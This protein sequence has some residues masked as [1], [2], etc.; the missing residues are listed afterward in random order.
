MS[1]DSLESPTSLSRNLTGAC[2]LAGPGGQSSD[3][4]WQRA[5]VTIPTGL[6]GGFLFFEGIR[7]NGVSGNIAVD[8]VTVVRSTGGVCE[9]RR[10]TGESVG[11]CPLHESVLMQTK[12]LFCAVAIEDQLFT[13]PMLRFA[14][15]DALFLRVPCRRPHLHLEA[16]TSPATSSRMRVRS[17]YGRSPRVSTADNTFFALSE[18]RD[19]ACLQRVLGF[20]VSL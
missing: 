7:G 12:D 13:D 19:L 6:G 1:L 8:D 3:Q 11:Q 18:Q 9:V 14:V 17:T 10:S 16:S 20:R 4:S 5:Q 15:H 2:F